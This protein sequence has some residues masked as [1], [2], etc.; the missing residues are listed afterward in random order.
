MR[1]L[2]DSVSPT[3]TADDGLSAVAAILAD[4]LLRLKQRRIQ[5]CP[6]SQ[7]TSPAGLELP[8]ET[9]LSVCHGG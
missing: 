2:T 3:T 7:N 4:A 8:D 1:S 5:T 9:R 6:D